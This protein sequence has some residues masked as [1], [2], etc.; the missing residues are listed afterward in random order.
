MII[1]QLQYI[2]SDFGKPY[3]TGKKA[4]VT[5][6]D[7]IVELQEDRSLFARM[8]VIS[9]SRR[10][11]DLRET[12]SRYEFSVVPRSMF[13]IDGTMLKVKSNL[14]TELE[15]L[16]P[17]ENANHA[18]SNDGRRDNDASGAAREV[19]IIDGMAEV[20]RLVKPYWIQNCCQLASKFTGQLLERHS[21]SDEIHVGGCKVIH[22]KVDART[23]P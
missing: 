6:G 4:K 3:L 19:V 11:V 5:T 13:A 18:G 2:E 8:L 20:Q 12:V 21:G 10:E 23:N 9:E 7:K 17:R 14:M 15:Q 1:T 16:L 22:S